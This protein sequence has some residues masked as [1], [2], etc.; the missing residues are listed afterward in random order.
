MPDLRLWGQLSAVYIPRV[1]WPAGRQ[2]TQA[3]TKASTLVATEVKGDLNGSPKD[4][5]VA[6]SDW[7]ERRPLTERASEMLREQDVP[8]DTLDQ[9]G[10]GRGIGL[11]RRWGVS[12]AGVVQIKRTVPMRWSDIKYHSHSST[13][14]LKKKKPTD[15]LL[16][17]RSRSLFLFRSIKTAS[18]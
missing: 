2:A 3:E 4:R 1:R 11:V 18:R 15:A 5:S 13:L 14:L 10:S 8:Y 17:A 7:P 9:L 16:S 12:E 6:Q